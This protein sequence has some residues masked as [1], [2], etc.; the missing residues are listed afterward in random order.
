MDV[1]PNDGDADL[2]TRIIEYET[3]RAL[4]Y[5][6]TLSCALLEI[7]PKI[8]PPSKN[9]TEALEKYARKVDHLLPISKNRY[10]F[11]FPE[12]GQEGLKVLL[13]RLVAHINSYIDRAHTNIT[14]SHWGY[15][16]LAPNISVMPPKKLIACL[17]QFHHEG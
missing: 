1:L 10:V 3:A 11:L 15:L 5:K 17:E 16:T 4:Q 2:L 8:C 12:T 6:R 7:K 9:V 13:P 14:S